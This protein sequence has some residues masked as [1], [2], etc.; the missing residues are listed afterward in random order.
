MM[1]ITR[2]L[3]QFPNSEG[4]VIIR[5]SKLILFLCLWG[6]FGQEV[7]AQ[8]PQE[9][10][11]V[12][13]LP[14]LLFEEVRKSQLEHH[15]FGG[16]KVY[17]PL[18]VNYFGEGVLQWQAEVI[19]LGFSLQVPHEIK[20]EIISALKKEE[21]LSCQN[22]A[23][24]ELPEVKRETT[25]E[26]H[27]QTKQESQEGW[28]DVAQVQIHVYPRDILK[29]LISWS[30][31]IQLRIRDKEGIFSQ[32]L[33]DHDILFVDSKAAVPKAKDQRI[34]TMVIGDPGERFLETRQG[35]PHESVVILRDEVDLIP[36][37]L[38]QPYRTGMLIDA[39]LNFVDRLVHDPQSQKMLVEIIRLTSTLK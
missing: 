33:E 30:E 10:V 34:V 16:Q 20:P 7:L 29:P 36:K 22:F 2:W 17:L 18:F 11:S 23:M 12:K 5:A 3:V 1:R 28:Q 27:F 15:Y 9:S 31:E 13:V 19:Q 32:F 4:G 14:H 39:H 8:T 21:Q 37:V 6:I 24:I 26:V 35:Y 38:V 25:F